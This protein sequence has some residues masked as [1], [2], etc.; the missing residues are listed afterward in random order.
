MLAAQEIV[1]GGDPYLN[2]INSLKSDATKKGYRNSLIR[3]MHHFDIKDTVTLSRLLAKDIELYLIKYFEYLKE[4]KIC[5]INGLYI[6]C[7]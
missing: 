1:L 6:K 5:K 3:F 2:F 7:S 4:Q